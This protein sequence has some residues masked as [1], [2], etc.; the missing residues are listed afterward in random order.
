MPATRRKGGGTV[1]DAS[2]SSSGGGGGGATQEEV[3]HG[4]V[5]FSLHQHESPKLIQCSYNTKVVGAAVRGG[6]G[7][8]A[9]M[10][11]QRGMN[12]VLNQL[13][14]R[15]VDPSVFGL[16]SIPLDLLLNTTL[17]LSREG[18]RLALGRRTLMG[19]S[20]DAREFR[21]FVN[22][23][24]VPAV[25]GPLV[26][27]LSLALLPSSS[28]GKGGEGGGQDPA[29][30]RQTGLLFCLAAA[31]ESLSEPAFLICQGCLL[32]SLRAASEGLA[33]LARSAITFGLL[34]WVLP[35]DKA[36]VAFGLAQVG[37]SLVLLAVYW[38]Y[39][40]YVGW[41]GKEEEEARKRK[42]KNND[43][44][45]KAGTPP[46]PPPPLRLLSLHH[47]LPGPPPSPS[48]PWMEPSHLSLAAA[49]TGQSFF[50]HLLTQG[51]KIVLSLGSSNYSQGLYALAQNYG[52]LAARL[53]FQPLEESGRL[54]FSRLAAA[55]AAG[56][57]GGG[58]EKEEVE[59]EEEH[60][61][62][63]SSS[64]AS[65]KKEGSSSSST[66][67]T[68]NKKTTLRL[69]LG[70]LVKT[71]VL[72]GLL[73]ACFGFNYTRVLLRLLLP[74]QRWKE[75]EGGKEGEGFS[76]VLS[77]YCLYV[78]FLAV[79]GMT[80][81]FVYAVATR[82]EVGRLSLSAA[83]SFVVF[84]LGTGPL[85]KGFGTVGLVVANCLGMLTRIGFSWGFIRRYFLQTEEGREG[86][87]EEEGSPEREGKKKGRLETKTEGGRG[88][89]GRMPDLFPRPVVLGAFG[90]ASVATRMSDRAMV[91]VEE[92]REVVRHV[93][94]GGLF[95]VGL[96]G[97][98]WCVEREFVR[99]LRGLRRLASGGG[100]GGGKERW[101][102]DKFTK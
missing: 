85:M 56:G 78:L 21:Q 87:V 18:F 66:T 11:L 48:T 37:Y 67:T 92:W 5:L 19:L 50:K 93:G 72:V 55:R 14:L 98:V 102:R 80:E 97:V 91:S 34:A 54:M 6:T 1:G 16:A 64:R 40:L 42:K 15:H 63:K 94:V 65:T 70:A 71:V 13:L 43:D 30:L 68:N 88:R 61:A 83:V 45:T 96:L 12:F 51:D 7:L 101:M 47:L 41:K 74:G 90:V 24:W 10:V 29:A 73:F 2:S 23:S 75:N 39:L 9:V 79:N 46:S 36:L 60:K 22:L 86:E 89:E 38:G 58:E 57:G 26:S 100:G 20:S 4:C 35:S 3:S 31:L 32:T 76:Q 25:M 27:L 77:W 53:F 17:F 52:S 95:L 28:G 8:M 44:A 49:L 69:M 84:A 59:E 99:D 81:A 62:G 33:T 82:E